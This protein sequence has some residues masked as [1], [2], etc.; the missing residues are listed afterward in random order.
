MTI[1]D[2]LLSSLNVEVPVHDVRIGKHWTAVAAMTPLGMRGGL[3]SSVSALDRH[4]HGQPPVGDAGRLLE[5]H[6]ADLAGLIRSQ[7]IAEASVGLATINALLNVDEEACVEVNAADILVSQG[8]GKRVAVVGHFP[9][10]RRV[11]R[12]AKT[13]W[14]LE[15]RPRGDDLSASRAAETIPQADVVGI[16]GSTLVNHTFDDIVA[17]CRPDAYVVVMGGSTP[18]SSLFFDFGVDAVA[19]TYVVDVEAVLRAVSQGA[20]FRQIPGK[21]LLTLFR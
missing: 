20:T 15:L 9:F 10:I 14:V 13:L 21:R 11:R 7:S 17:L 4:T 19:G 3:A 18:L 16:T 5:H 8:A 12:A 2:A 6:A 1:I